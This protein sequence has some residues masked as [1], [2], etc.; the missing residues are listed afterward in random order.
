MPKNYTNSSGD[1]TVITIS[2]GVTTIPFASVDLA[3]LAVATDPSTGFYTAIVNDPNNS[4][5]LNITSN[6]TITVNASITNGTKTCQR[7]LTKTLLVQCPVVTNVSA[8]LV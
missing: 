3:S 6:Y 4:K 2:D 1:G 8:T 5:N 7:T